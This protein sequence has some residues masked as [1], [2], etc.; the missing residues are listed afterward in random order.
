MPDSAGTAT[1]YLT[2]V[3]AN[4]KTIG[5]NG[6][7]KLDTPDCDLL[8]NNSVTSILA[9]GIEAGKAAGIV[10]TTRVTHATPAGTYAHTQNRNWEEKL[11]SDIFFKGRCKDIASQLIEDYPGNRFNV[12]MGGGRG[13]MTPNTQFDPKGLKQHGRLVPVKGMLSLFLLKF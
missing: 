9:W 10:T 5:V 12:I 4:Y 6:H 2:G 3:K 13:M 11:P 8:H 1:A 7:V